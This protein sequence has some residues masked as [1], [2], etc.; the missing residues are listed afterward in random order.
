MSMFYIGGELAQSRLGLPKSLTG[1]FQGLLLF[2]LLACDTLIHYRMRWR[3][4]RPRRPVHAAMPA[5]TVGRRADGIRPA[6]RRHPQCRHRARSPALGLLINERAGI[7]NLGAE[8]M[9]LVAAVAGFATAVHTGSDWLAFAAG[10]AAGALL[11]AVFGVLV[12]WLNTNQYA[13]GLALS[14]FGV[15]FSAFV[16]IRYTQ[17]KLR[18]ASRASQIPA[19]RHAVRRAGAVPPAPDGLSRDR[20][21]DRRWP[22]SSTARAPGWCCARSANRPSRRMRWATRCGASAW[23]R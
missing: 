8:G 14:L 6:H 3:G 23:P 10:A 2:T 15:G 18:R 7:V 4:V 19:G 9:M 11:A 5:L 20:A 16:G 13:T 17:E 21:G 22:G 12:I 1:V